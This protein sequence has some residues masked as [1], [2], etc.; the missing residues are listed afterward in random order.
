[1]AGVLSEVV[2]RVDDHR[3]RPDP[4]RH[5]PLGHRGQRRDH[6]GDDVGV[7]R[8]M[9]VGPRR[10]VPGV[11]ADQPDARGGHDRRQLRVGTFPRVVDQVGAGLDAGRGHRRPPGVDADHD[12]GVGGPHRGDDVDDPGD[13]LG[14]ADLRAL[15]G[16]H[17]ADVH[18]ARA[19]G[20]RP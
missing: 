9:W 16:L 10:Q 20:D 5:R 3:V 17:P 4:R 1:V 19:G 6:V 13:L 14:N 18:D 8:A 7:R 12:V 11:R 15:A 2:T